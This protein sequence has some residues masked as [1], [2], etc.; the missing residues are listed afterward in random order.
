MYGFH[1]LEGIFLF[2]LEALVD[3]LEYL[4]LD[5]ASETVFLGSLRNGTRGQVKI[6]LVNHLT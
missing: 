5:L 4:M 3:L 1:A 2:V 6:N